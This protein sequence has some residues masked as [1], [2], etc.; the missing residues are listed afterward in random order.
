[1]N[2]DIRG[3]QTHLRAIADDLARQIE[4]HKRDASLLTMPEVCDTQEEIDRARAN[5]QR[6]IPLVAR[7][8]NLCAVLLTIEG[9][10]ATL[11]ALAN[12]RTGA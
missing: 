4:Q 12:A 8:G 10:L 9:A 11:D 3:A 6:A 5:V 2:D 7:V 1:M